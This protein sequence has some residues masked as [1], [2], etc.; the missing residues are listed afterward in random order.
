MPW[1]DEERRG[2]VFEVDDSGS[3]RS[4]CVWAD[5]VDGVVA[6]SGG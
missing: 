4:S 2:Q 3:E 6:F 1:T 5:G